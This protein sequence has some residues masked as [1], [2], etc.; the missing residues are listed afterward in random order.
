VTGD[1]GTVDL[2][3][4]GAHLT[5][6]PL[7]GQLTDLGAELVGPVRTAPCYR[8]VALPTEPPKPGLVRL[9]EGGSSIEGERWRLS[10]EAFGSFVAVVPAPLTIG[11]LALDGGASCLGF[12]CESYAAEGAP[13]ITELGGWRAH[14]AR[15]NAG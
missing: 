5:G 15:D 11:T 1:G 2:V 9:A 3:V 12:L 8:L 14:R 10:T 4:V 6:E 13:D 7:N